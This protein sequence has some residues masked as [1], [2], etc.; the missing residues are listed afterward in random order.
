MIELLNQSVDNDK[1]TWFSVAPHC[2]KYIDRFNKGDV[3]EVESK[4]D[5]VKMVITHIKKYSGISKDNAQDDLGGSLGSSL[6]G[7]LDGEL[8]EPSIKKFNTFNVNKPT[9]DPL[10]HEK[11]RMA[12]KEE[13]E[14]KNRQGTLGAV[15]TIVSSLGFTKNDKTEDIV[16]VVEC[17]YEALIKKVCVSNLTLG[18]ITADSIDDIAPPVKK[19][20]VLPTKT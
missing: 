17:L 4:K 9:F 6:G 5:G 20:Q 8:E 2:K 15:A 12:D 13:A 18:S 11:K 14:R 19:E 16:K 10:Y 1:A 7:S 3:V